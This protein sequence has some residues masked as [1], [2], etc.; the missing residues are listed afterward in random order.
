[1]TTERP[2]LQLER[3]A[4]A[5]RRTALGLA[6]AG[7]LAAKLTFHALG[8]LAAAV[9]VLLAVGLWLVGGHRYRRERATAPSRPPGGAALAQLAALTAVVGVLALIFVLR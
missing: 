8:L 5:W 1:M 3:T 7:A 4:L 9:G 6:V 2:G